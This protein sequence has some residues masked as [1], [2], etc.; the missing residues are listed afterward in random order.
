MPAAPIINSGSGRLLAVDIWLIIG[1]KGI[2]TTSTSLLH[3]SLSLLSLIQLPYFVVPVVERL[4][5]IL[6]LLADF[7]LTI[8]INK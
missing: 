6:H 4:R 8:R 1:P 2:I 5:E 3:T 7:T